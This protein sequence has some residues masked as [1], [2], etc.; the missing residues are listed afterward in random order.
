MKKES[1]SHIPATMIVV[2]SRL[3]RRNRTGAGTQQAGE[4]GQGKDLFHGFRLSLRLNERRAG[5]LPLSGP[6][7]RQISKKFVPI[8]EN[9]GM[10][11][12]FLPRSLRGEGSP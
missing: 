12:S 9:R 1:L 3:I 6:F 11:I 10:K 7:A 5:K 4:D 2:R 8:P